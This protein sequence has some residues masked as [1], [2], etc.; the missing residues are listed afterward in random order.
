MFYSGRCRL[1]DLNLQMYETEIERFKEVQFLA[2]T[3]DEKFHFKAHV[4]NLK[5]K[6]ADRSAHLRKQSLGPETAY[7][8]QLVWIVGTLTIRVCCHCEVESSS[9]KT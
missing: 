2:V 7:V 4:A 6:C 1:G 9:K 8:N 3:F 5:K